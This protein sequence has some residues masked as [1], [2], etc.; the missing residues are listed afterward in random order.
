MKYNCILPAL[1][2][3]EIPNLEIIVNLALSKQTRQSSTLTPT[4]S[5]DKAVDGNR[6]QDVLFHSCAHTDIG[7]TVA[8]WQV[9]LGIIATIT[10]IQIYYRENCKSLKTKRA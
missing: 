6:N 2:I 10:N 7:Y 8:W 9:D 4:W 1:K 5:A 3:Q